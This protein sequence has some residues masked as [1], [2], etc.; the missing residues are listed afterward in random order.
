MSADLQ[1]VTRNNWQEMIQLT[2]FPL[3]FS[4]RDVPLF[5]QIYQLFKEEICITIY[6]IT[7]FFLLYEG[8]QGY[9]TLA[10]IQ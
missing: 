7:T 3:D 10:R 1:P 2:E 5:F 8:A 4:S 6:S 9:C